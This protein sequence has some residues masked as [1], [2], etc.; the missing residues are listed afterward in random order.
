MHHGG[1]RLIGVATA[2]LLVLSCSVASAESQTFNSIFFQ[3]A[4]GRNPYLMLHSS[5]TLHQLQFDVG[6]VFSFAYHPLDLRQGNTR[7]QGVIDQLMVADFVAAFGAMDWLQVG[8]D[9]PLI[10]INKFSDPLINPP[11]AAVNHF[12]IGDIRFEIKARVLNA[13]DKYIGLA[14]IPFVTVPTG[15]DAHFV[16]DPG[17]TG[18]IKVALDGRVHKNI[19]LTLNVGYQ[20]G[21][22]RVNISNINFQHRFLLGAGVDGKFSHGID[23]FAEINT[24][25]AMNKLLHDRD[26]NPTEAMVGARWE[27]KETGIT[28][29]GGGGTC[30]VCGAKG[31]R[32]RGVLGVKYRFNPQKFRDM[33]ARDSQMCMARF[34]KGLSAQRFMELRGTCPDNPA[35]YQP[36]AN[37]AACPKYYELREVSDLVFR[38]PSRPEDFNPKYH[39]AACPKVFNLADAYSAE[40]IRNIYSAAAAGM[41]ILCP[42]DPSSFNPQLHDM[43]CPK[44]YDLREAVALAKQCPPEAGEYK[45]GMDDA[46]CPKFYT[47]RDEFTSSQWAAITRMSDKDW[48]RFGGDE[49]V[50]GEIQTLKPIYFDFNKVQIR[51]ESIPELDQIVEIVNKT[52]WVHRLHIGGHADARGTSDA[53]ELISRK[54]SLAVIKYLSDHGIRRDVDL[55]PVAYGA[56]RPAAPNDTEQGR[57]LNRRVVFIVTG[58]HYQSLPIP[59]APGKSVKTKPVQEELAPV[60]DGEEPQS[61][62]TPPKRWQ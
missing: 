3:P 52:T 32:V 1:K 48:K 7:V 31:S 29:Q 55:V 47:L 56:N 40:D 36:G 62:A 34:G 18:G 2:L 28:V 61:P 17:F 50:G 53:N 33:D 16:G 51:P 21:M 11:P 5:E 37:D 27:I 15:K 43:G 26:M 30:L 13:C 35:D 57:A 22:Q 45:E 42:P 41:S 44:Y 60:Q 38:C 49:I 8:V 46:S 19:G 59:K 25:A 20:G 10:L 39:D 58:D 9:F 24:I 6:E 54:R 14:F 23:V 4:T 12:D